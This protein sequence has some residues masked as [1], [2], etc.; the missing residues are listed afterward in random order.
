MF[1]CCNLHPLRLLLLY[2]TEQELCRILQCCPQGVRKD[3][4]PL[5]KKSPFLL[6]TPH[7]LGHKFCLT[8]RS[9]AEVQLGTV[10][11]QLLNPH[12][13]FH[14]DVTVR[15]KQVDQMSLLAT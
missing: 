2:L 9:P 14:D 5:A 4:G 12:S 8:T 15:I 10:R 1:L 6:L 11:V 13:D 7:K 3:I